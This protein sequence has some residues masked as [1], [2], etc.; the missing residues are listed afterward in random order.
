MVM[1]SLRLVVMGTTISAKSAVTNCNTHLSVFNTTKLYTHHPQVFHPSPPHVLSPYP[2]LPTK[3][4]KKRHPVFSKLE[5]P[6]KKNAANK[7]SFNT[8]SLLRGKRGK[9]CSYGLLPF[10]P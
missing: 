9:T 10:A 8:F 7:F 2:L 5:I 1:E 4:L 3:P 6:K